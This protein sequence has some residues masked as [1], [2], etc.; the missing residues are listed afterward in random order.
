MPVMNA[1]R[2]VA[3]LRELADLAGEPVARVA[4][5]RTP[6]EALR[7]VGRGCSRG[8]LAQIGNNALGVHDRHCRSMETG[9]E[10]TEKTI[11]KRSEDQETRCGRAARC[12]KH[13]LLA[14]S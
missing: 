10:D 13:P 6:G 9:T 5:H 11:H 2:V 8:E 3:D 1:Q 12:A 7:A 4:P 14:N